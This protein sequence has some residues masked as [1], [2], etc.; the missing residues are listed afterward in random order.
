MILVG[1]DYR[2]ALGDSGMFGRL[3]NGTITGRLDPCARF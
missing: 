3:M 1:M 2:N